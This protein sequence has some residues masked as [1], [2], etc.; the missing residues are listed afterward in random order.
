MYF[1]EAI[2]E[3]HLLN[4]AENKK[5]IVMGLGMSYPSEGLAKKFP[6]QVFDT[7]ASEA[8]IT[9]MAVGLASQGY[10]PMV[11]HGRTEFA[12]LAMDQILTQASRWNYMFGGNYSCSIS[13]RVAIGRQWGN[14][15]Q[16]TANY[17]SIFLQASGL[18][19]FIPSTPKEIFEHLRFMSTNNNPS[20]LLE[21]RWLYKSRQN[22]P[23]DNKPILKVPICSIYKENN[24][25]DILIVTY[26]DGLI[27]ALKA[28]KILKQNN[29]F[30][31]VLNV[32]SFP[33]NNRVNKKI[34]NFI[35]DFKRV[36][37]VDTA[38][39]EFGLLSSLSG[40]VSLTG[41]INNLFYYL[42][43]PHKP[44]PTSPSLSKNYYI[45]Y[46]D[47]VKKIFNLLKVNFNGLEKPT[48]NELNLW[49]E[50]DF[51]DYDAINFY[52]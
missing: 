35:K 20:V 52:S 37:F 29:V 38:P 26:A 22:F 4:L 15:P 45:T 30:V 19:V 23:I 43:P 17:H 46:Y 1:T 47:I 21:H 8:A 41:S 40:L 11:V 49:P 16:H 31:T 14:G 34:V 10:R 24:S 9:G 44:C 6:N 36:L 28:Q 18:D 51:T 33:A 42:S 13:L 25:S 48:F 27:D 2:K 7:P 32:S 39:I 3:A 5:S 50:F 12:L